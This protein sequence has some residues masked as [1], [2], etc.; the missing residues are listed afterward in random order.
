MATTLSYGFVKP[1]DG[2]KGDVFW[3][4]L[5]DDIQQLN[6]HNHNG[7]NSAKLTSASMTAVTS[8]IASGSWG[9]LTAGLYSQVVSMP[10]GQ[11]FDDYAI[12][13]RNSGDNSVVH[14]SVEKV[15]DATYRVYVNDN[16]LN[17]VALYQ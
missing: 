6:D 16:T 11:D 7:T 12:E 1:Q 10:A 13:F 2:D 14:P 4:A 17:L 8:A 3:D 9:A 5:E 15:T